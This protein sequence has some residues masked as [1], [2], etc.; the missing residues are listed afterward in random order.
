MYTADLN[1]RSDEVRPSGERALDDGAIC[2]LF[3][4][5]KQTL[6]R[7]RRKH[8]FPRPDFYVGPRGFT[9]ESRPH[10]WAR[11]QPSNS[12]ISNRAWSAVGLARSGSGRV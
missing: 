2:Q 9:W 7:W 3:G 4:I 1:Q 5:S 8:A 12:S 10:E 11:Q 6:T